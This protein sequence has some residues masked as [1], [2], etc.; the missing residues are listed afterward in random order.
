MRALTARYHSFLLR[1]WRDDF[2]GDWRASL[3]DVKTG[4]CHYFASMDAMITFLASTTS[5]SSP[6]LRTFHEVV[7]QEK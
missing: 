3:Q 6:F 4:D 2:E 5:E 1:L 7:A